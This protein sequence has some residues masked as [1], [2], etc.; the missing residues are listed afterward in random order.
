MTRLVPATRTETPMMLSVDPSGAAQADITASTGD[1]WRILWR[2]KGLIASTVALL[3]VVALVYGL[4]TPPL[5]TASAQI[6]VDPRDRQVLVNDVNPTGMAPDGGITQV[7]SQ[8]E[9]IQSSTVLLRAIAAV[10]LDQ[11]PEFSQ[12]GPLVQLLH[13]LPKDLVPA[14]PEDTPAARTMRTLKRRLS[15]TR[16]EKVFVIEL[17]VTANTAE[18]SARIANAIADAYLAD[19]ADAKAQSGERASAAL[20]AR[21][22]AQRAHV[23]ALDNEIQAYS[24]SHKILM[25]NGQLV[26]DQKLVDFSAQLTAAQSRSAM[27]R[28]KIDQ[29]QQPNISTAS[30][31]EVMQSQVIAHLRQEEGTLVQK[32]VEME[33]RLGPTYPTIAPVRAQLASVRALMTSE[34]N[35][36]LATMKGDYERARIDEQ[37]ITHQVDQAR[38][39][40]EAARQASVR[41]R[42]LERDLDAS[43]TVYAAF[44]ARARE[45]REQVGIDTTNARIITRATAPLQKSWPPL[46]LLLMGS[47]GTGIG[48]GGGLAL[49]REYVAP[50]ILSRGQMERS[51]GAPVIGVIPGRGLTRTRRP[52]RQGMS[53]RKP[54]PSVL[55]IMGLALRR[56]LDADIDAGMREN[57]GLRSVLVTS[58]TQDADIR[59]EACILFASAATMRGDRVLLVDADV[60][61]GK[62]DAS[63]GLLDVLHGEKNLSSL[64]DLAAPTGV[65]FLG[66]GRDQRSAA[67]SHRGWTGVMR[68]LAEARQHFDLIVI[69][70]GVIAENLQVAPLL[71][72]VDEV[73]LVAQLAKTTQNE[74]YRAADAASIMGRPISAV[75]LVDPMVQA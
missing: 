49:M 53:G 25:A 13:M 44:L 40:A 36:I 10:H 63:E 56:L 6:I 59:Q 67:L 35:R 4:A 19:Q 5:Y 8:V 52:L 38:A 47:I 60:A 32:Q 55:A 34:I 72:A 27:L 73:L 21:L 24:K 12:A 58:G 23:E 57:A 3:F 29:L 26:G 20:T 17:S 48:L 54:S 74:A 18:K 22:E 64:V 11:D 30:L 28:S 69:D 2:R 45:T 7:E 65:A 51:T 16:A 37:L 66:K 39:D 42:E 41:L 14:Q 62:P 50:T 75:L 46:G 71:N 68:M 33:S 43:R 15:V 31:R 9:V 1:L 70:G 61:G